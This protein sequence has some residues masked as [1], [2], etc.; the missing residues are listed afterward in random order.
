MPN[1]DPVIE[2]AAM[3]ESEDALR[4]LVQVFQNVGLGKPQVATML[5]AI[6]DQIDPP[7]VI[8]LQ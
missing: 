6:A 7:T 5:R 4:E 3:R 2:A 8:T 1:L